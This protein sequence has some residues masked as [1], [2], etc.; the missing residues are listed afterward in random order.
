MDAKLGLTEIRITNKGSGAHCTILMDANG[1]MTVKTTSSVNIST[2]V[3]TV[4][5]EMLTVDTKTMGVKCSGDCSFNADKVSFSNKVNIGA[6][7][8]G[9]I[10]GNSIA[11]VV[12]GIVTKIS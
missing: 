2:P 12:N 5:S 6:G 11:S 9:T 10:N 7:A 8:T 4:T 3:A 1:N